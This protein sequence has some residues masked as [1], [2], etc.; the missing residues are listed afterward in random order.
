MNIN[1]S[2]H[3]A[4]VIVTAAIPLAVLTHRLTRRLGD[5]L[6]VARMSRAPRSRLALRHPKVLGTDADG[7]LIM[8][9]P[10]LLVSSTS[11]GKLRFRRLRDAEVLFPA[12]HLDSV[13]EDAVLELLAFGP[14][15][16]EMEWSRGSL[17]A[18]SVQFR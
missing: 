14:Q 1:S 5:A 2:G 9:G 16:V 7:D 13:R 4:L 11:S 3:W 6:A 15:K 18:S 8:R 10:A 17:A 12:G